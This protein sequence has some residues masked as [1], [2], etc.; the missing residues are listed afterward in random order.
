MKVPRK[1]KKQI[2]TGLYCYT[3]TS[4]FK[5]FPDG[6]WGF[7]TKVCPFYSHIKIKDIQL[8]DRPKW[9][10]EE[11]VNEHGNRIES[12]CKLVKTDIMDQCKSCGLKYGKL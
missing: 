11:F 2:P 5:K 1:K 9:M 12:W 8:A 10:D 6:S 3:A 4:G 7:T